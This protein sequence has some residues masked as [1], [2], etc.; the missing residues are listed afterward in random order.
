MERIESEINEKVKLKLQ[1][2]IKKGDYKKLINELDLAIETLD[3][4]DLTFK[5]TRDK[6]KKENSDYSWEE[7]PN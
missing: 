1:E 4:F 3:S 7:G 5:T 6:I 2:S